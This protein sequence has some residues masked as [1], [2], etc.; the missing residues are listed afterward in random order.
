MR[1]LLTL[2]ALLVSVSG[3]AV[4]LAREEVR[5]YLGL[6]SVKCLAT[7]KSQPTQRVTESKP[8]ESPEEKVVPPPQKTTESNPE[9]KSSQ[10]TESKPLEV[11]PPPESTS[12]PLEVIP[13]PEQ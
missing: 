8:P 6:E 5:C 3:I 11:V 1:N 12:I 9:E 13:P 10:K 7:E 2:V 4:S